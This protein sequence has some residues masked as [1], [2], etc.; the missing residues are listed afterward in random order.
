LQPAAAA[1]RSAHERRDF[2]G[3]R[4]VYFAEP[5]P[6][7]FGPAEGKHPDEFAVGFQHRGND[8]PGVFDRREIP[9]WSIEGR[10]LR[11]YIRV[12]DPGSALADGTRKLIVQPRS[13]L[14]FKHGVTKAL[15]ER[16][17]DVDECEP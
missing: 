12:D 15:L 1:E 10:G 17:I 9:L 3:E 7:G 4:Y 8:F 11:P 13:R 16:P 6:A 2:L 14:G 5:G